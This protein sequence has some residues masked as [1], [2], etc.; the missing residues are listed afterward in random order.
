M[1]KENQTF[2]PFKRKQ[3]SGTA[4]V[5]ASVTKLHTHLRSFV[6]FMSQFQGRDIFHE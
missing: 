4:Q 5:C 2:F 6:S 1:L 3:N